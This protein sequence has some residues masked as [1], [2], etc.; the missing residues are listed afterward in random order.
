MRIKL[1][2]QPLAAPGVRLGATFGDVPGAASAWRAVPSSCR[3]SRGH[4]RPSLRVG[5]RH[6]GALLGSPQ[7]VRPARHLRLS[8]RYTDSIL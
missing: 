2:A 6:R 7:G 8:S 3:V 5:G 1:R 4:V